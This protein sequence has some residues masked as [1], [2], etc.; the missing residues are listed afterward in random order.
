M[1]YRG[2]GENTQRL[3]K[4]C[5][6]RR[7]WK[8]Q[9]PGK[10]NPGRLRILRYAEPEFVTV[11]RPRRRRKEDEGDGGGGCDDDGNVYILFL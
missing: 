6:P 10:R 1:Q 3:E 4:H 2:N 7:A 5:L 9:S 11:P 8:Y